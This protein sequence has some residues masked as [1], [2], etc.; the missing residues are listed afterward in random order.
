MLSLHFAASTR[1]GC[2]LMCHP[3]QHI[4]AGLMHKLRVFKEK[5]DIY[6]FEEEQ[7]NASYTDGQQSQDRTK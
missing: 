1:M 7:I 4:L 5:D 2:E 6:I 3:R